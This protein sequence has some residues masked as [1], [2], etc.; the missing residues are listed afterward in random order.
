LAITGPRSILPPR[1]PHGD[2]VRPRRV[3]RRNKR[4][5]CEL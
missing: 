1:R 5:S 4:G 2:P 3:D